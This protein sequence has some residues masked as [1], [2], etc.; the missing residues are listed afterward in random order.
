ME[1]RSS[2]RSPSWSV[3]QAGLLH[4]VGE[5]GPHRDVVD[6]PLDESHGHVMSFLILFV[7][8][9]LRTNAGIRPMAK[10]GVFCGALSS[11]GE[12]VQDMVTMTNATSEEK[13]YKH[14]S[15]TIITLW[16]SYFVLELLL[17]KSKVNSFSCILVALSDHGPSSFHAFRSFWGSKQHMPIMRTRTFRRPAVHFFL[18]RF[19]KEDGLNTQAFGRFV[20]ATDPQG[21][22]D[23]SR[24]M[25]QAGHGIPF[26][27]FLGALRLDLAGIPCILLRMFERFGWLYL[28]WSLKLMVSGFCWKLCPVISYFFYL[29]FDSF[30]W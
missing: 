22:L 4:R 20:I 14:N 17:V 5:L 23:V 27:G 11:K 7:V 25:R 18:I 6:V 16:A 19:T 26:A 9:L 3:H 29:F 12:G 30:E 15:I 1:M 13:Q 10:L 28:I 24:P 8:P 2:W 21:L